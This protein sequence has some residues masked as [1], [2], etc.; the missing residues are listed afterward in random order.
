MVY[1]KHVQGDGHLTAT[2]C[3]SRVWRV[4]VQ[5][6]PNS[7]GPY[8]RTLV[9]IYSTTVTSGIAVLHSSSAMFRKSLHVHAGF[10]PRVEDD[11]ATANLWHYAIVKSNCCSSYQ[12]V[13]PAFDITT[14]LIPN[15]MR[16]IERKSTDAVRESALAGNA[17]DC[18]E[19]GLR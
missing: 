17:D 19:M 5:P 13:D 14:S 1:K 12:D 3:S 16:D 4:G 11:P 2:T 18:L 7:N 9:P 8:P 6:R 15:A 10:V